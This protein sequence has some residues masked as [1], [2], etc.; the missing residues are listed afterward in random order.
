MATEEKIKSKFETTKAAVKFL[1][2]RYPELRNDD[3]PLILYYWY[4]MD[5]F[6]IFLPSNRT[7][8]LTSSETIRR[9]RQK[10]Q[11]DGEFVPTDPKVI[12][13]R[14]I[15]RH[16]IKNYFAKEYGIH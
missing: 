14:R 13:M 7:A 5:K 1:L 9:A 8:R 6:P 4:Y 2:A 16:A 11:A 15:R 10:I 3:R 12:Q